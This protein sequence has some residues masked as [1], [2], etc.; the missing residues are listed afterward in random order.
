MGLWPMPCSIPSP[1]RSSPEPPC[2][3]LISQRSSTA[4]EIS[5]GP[6]MVTCCPG[7]SQSASKVGSM[8]S[9][10]LETMSEPRTASSAE[11]TGCISIFRRRLIS[12]AK[13]SRF[14]LVGL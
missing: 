3:I 12:L 8:E 9:V 1:F 6:S 2:E 11:S 13:D 7:D 4:L 10:Q 5:M 14:A